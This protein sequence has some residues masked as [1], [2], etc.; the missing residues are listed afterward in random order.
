MDSITF[1]VLFLI[2]IWVVSIFM[3][4][5]NL[6]IARVRNDGVG[7]AMNTVVLITLLFIA[8]FVYYS[9]MVKIS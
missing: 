6:V 9:A 2:V 3:A 5:V 1:I 8:I 7:T 4:I